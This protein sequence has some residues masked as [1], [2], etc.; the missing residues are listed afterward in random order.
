MLVFFDDEL[1]TFRNENDRFICYV[2]KNK[3]SFMRCEKCT[4]FTQNAHFKFDILYVWLSFTLFNH[5]GLF[6]VKR[7]SLI[8]LHVQLNYFR[9]DWNNATFRISMGRTFN[10]VWVGLNTFLLM[11]TT[12][13]RFE[14]ITIEF[15]STL[16]YTP[17]IFREHSL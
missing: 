17:F 12:N 1:K 11:D 14:A 9:S 13:R 6:F 2:Q 16:A 4:G 8:R 15:D 5:I 3:K 7:L 10:S